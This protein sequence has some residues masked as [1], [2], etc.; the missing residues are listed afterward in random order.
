M[1]PARGWHVPCSSVSSLKHRPRCQVR[2][3]EEERDEDCYATERWAGAFSRSIAMPQGVDG[4][5]VE[6]SFKNGV[7]EIRVPK[8]KEAMGRKIEIKVA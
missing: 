3:R 8:T 5:R 2:I 7:L 6:A 4:E 1:M